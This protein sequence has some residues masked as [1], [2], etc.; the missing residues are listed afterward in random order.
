MTGCIA[1][2][3]SRVLDS[4][5]FMNNLL[6]AKSAQCAAIAGCLGGTLPNDP[7]CSDMCDALAKCGLLPS[8]TWGSDAIQC[9]FGCT[10]YFA[11]VGGKDREAITSC[12]T[13]NLPAF[14]DPD[15]PVLCSIAGDPK[16]CTD[17]CA[18]NADC[19]KLAF[20]GGASCQDYC[21]GLFP[22]ARLALA[23][24]MVTTSCGKMATDRCLPPA[25]VKS[26]NQDAFCKAISATCGSDSQDIPSEQPWCAW[27]ATGLEAGLG[28]GADLSGTAACLG[29]EGVDPCGTETW[30]AAACAATEVAGCTPY[31][32]RLV[33]CK[34]VQ[35]ND[36]D[37]FRCARL[38]D[39][40]A[41]L[42]ATS[43]DLILACVSGAA[44][45]EAA[46]KCVP[47]I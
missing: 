12:V 7:S 47:E 19:A 33:E 22:G 3:K 30:L 8:E 14:C 11:S 34:V 38:C 5:D 37:R 21:Q 40:A 17:A 20:P 42:D 16:V 35:D 24:C 2:C 15:V 41:A 36:A 44:D 23:A 43:L 28:L 39:L 6:C 26:D 10:G 31:C 4:T 1:M 18:T 13:A 25:L 27:V 45:C 32:D 29:H 9:T 46:V